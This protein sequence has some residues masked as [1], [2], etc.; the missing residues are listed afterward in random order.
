MSVYNIIKQFK[1][2]GEYIDLRENFNCGKATYKANDFVLDGRLLSK[3]KD[4][5]TA[6]NVP[7]GAW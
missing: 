2:R 5:L 3:L 6:R 7:G 4:F 1:Q